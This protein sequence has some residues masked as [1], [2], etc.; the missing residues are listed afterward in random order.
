MI[1]T[2]GQLNHLLFYQNLQQ[3]W[4]GLTQQ[5]TMSFALPDLNDEVH[6][7]QITAIEDSLEWMLAN[8]DGDVYADK[9][10]ENE[11]ENDLP[12]S[13]NEGEFNEVVGAALDDRLD[14]YQ[15]GDDNGY[16]SY[17]TN[18]K[19]AQ[20]ACCRYETNLG[21]FQFAANGENIVLKLGQLFKDIDEYRNVVKVYAINNAF[22]LERVKNEKT[23]VTLRCAATRC[24]W[25][26]NDSP[27]WSKGHFQIKTYCLEHTCPRNNKNYEATSTWITIYF[28]HLFKPNTQLPIDVIASELFRRYEITYCN[29]GYIRQETRPQNYWDKTIKQATTNYSVICMLY[30][31]KSWFHRIIG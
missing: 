9:L 11:I 22:R 24:T 12:H 3:K 18:D 1:E 23:R 26:L 28:L 27:N 17:E 10:T 13:D 6:I 4:A 20:A 29:K 5:T 21:G 15:F 31:F 14:D 30:F 7:E 16:D 19:A 25:R 8:D 2:K